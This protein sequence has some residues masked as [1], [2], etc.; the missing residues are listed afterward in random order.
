MSAESL[1]RRNLI[2]YGFGGLVVPFIG[3]KLIDMFITGV[4]LA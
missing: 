3:I 1:L 2:V 4:K